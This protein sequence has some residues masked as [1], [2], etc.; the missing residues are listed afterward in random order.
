MHRFYILYIIFVISQNLVWILYHWEV[1]ETCDSITARGMDHML[2]RRRNTY[3]VPEVS[4]IDT[5]KR[6]KISSTSGHRFESNVRIFG[7]NRVYHPYCCPRAW[8]SFK[9]EKYQLL[10]VFGLCY[11]W[12]VNII[13]IS[14]VCKQNLNFRL[15]HAQCKNLK[16]S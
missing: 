2:G 15:I 13:V 6:F 12:L 1:Y 11:I 14:W 3:P 10:P 16:S 4:Q 8:I 7:K 9:W 5:I